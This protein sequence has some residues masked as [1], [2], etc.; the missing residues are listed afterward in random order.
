V[1]HCFFVTVYR[2]HLC[3]DLFGCIAARE[4]NELTYLMSVL[5]NSE[6]IMG[7]VRDDLLYIWRVIYTN[8]FHSSHYNTALFDLRKVTLSHLRPFQAIY[9]TSSVFALPSKYSD[10]HSF[11]NDATVIATT[12]R[13]LQPSMFTKFKVQLMPRHRILPPV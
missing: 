7:P 1:F 5:G 2:I 4:F 6:Y 10:W 3:I 9:L 8:P 12:N 11:H 13:H